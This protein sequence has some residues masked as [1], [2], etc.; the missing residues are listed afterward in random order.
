MATREITMADF[1]TTVTAGGIVLLD[2]W[3]AWCPPCRSFRPVFDAASEQHLDLVFGTV[4]TEAEQEL[5]AACQISSIPTLMAFREGLLV[6]AEPGALTAR[7][8]DQ[9]IEA[10]RG[11]DMDEVRRAA[12]ASEA[13]A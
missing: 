13:T 2:F 11:L 7:Q 9:V 5:A 10:V 3:A 4:D 12:A 8:L 1:E 6:F